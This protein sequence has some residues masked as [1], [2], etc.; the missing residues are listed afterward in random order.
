[1][2]LPLL[3]WQVSPDWP[4][5]VAYAWLF[6]QTVGRSWRARRQGRLSLQDPYNPER[7]KQVHDPLQIIHHS[8][9]SVVMPLYLACWMT[10][11][12]RPNGVF[13]VA[14]VLLYGLYLPQRWAAMWPLRPLLTWLRIVR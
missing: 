12:Y 3:K 2:T 13:V 10:V 9:P 8:L 7:Q 5:A 14:L 11:L 6:F 1:V 4:L